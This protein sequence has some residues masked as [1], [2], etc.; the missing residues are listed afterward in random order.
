MQLAIATLDD[1]GYQVMLFL[2]ILAAMVA[3]APGFVWPVVSVALKK[4]GKPVGPAIGELAANNTV[5]VHGPAL[6]LTGVF[7]F[8]LIG[9]S[10]DLISFSDAWISAAMLVWFLMLGLVYGVMLPAEKKAA[11][12]D[13]GA[14]KIISAVGGGLHLLLAVMLFLM[15]FQ[16]GR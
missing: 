10:E 3:M 16:P 9:M 12:G 14:E 2:H 6:V 8:G 4:A 5:K 13:E 15:V 7:G 11:T 1:T